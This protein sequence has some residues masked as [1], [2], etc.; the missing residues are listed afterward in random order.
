[1]VNAMVN[2][3]PSSYAFNDSPNKMTYLQNSSAEAS[4][5]S[6]STLS[7]SFEG[8]FIVKIGSRDQTQNRAKYS[9]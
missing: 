3:M 5:K 9:L 8:I 6:I 1:M 2:I 7:S 4:E